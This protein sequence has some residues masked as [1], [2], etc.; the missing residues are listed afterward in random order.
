[1]SCCKA[2][3]VGGFLASL[4]A[5]APAIA[6]TPAEAFARG[7]AQLREGKLDQAIEAF[8]AAAAA[9]HD[10]A[11]YAARAKQLHK[12]AALQERLDKEKDDGPWTRIA[13]ALHLFYRSEHID[14]EA[15]K[16]DQ[17]IHERLKSALSASILADTLLATGRNAEV[18]ELLDGLPDD[19]RDLGTSVVYVV[20]LARAGRKD[21]AIS[22]ANAVKLPEDICPGKAFL[23][24]RMYG[25][26]GRD[27]EAA[28]L[29]TTAFESTSAEKLPNFQKSAKENPDFAT[30]VADEKYASL[31]T[32]KTN[33][34]LEHKDDH[35]K[36]DGRSHC[37]GCPSLDRVQDIATEGG[38][39]SC[40]T[41]G[42]TPKLKLKQTKTPE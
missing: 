23:L 16:I 42:V 9:D 4:L 13:R 2:L 30:L 31:W 34:A 29:L 14:A 26:V 38:E 21:D 18:V 6:E 1:M 15:V 33:P 5:A 39:A 37:M 36:N 25:A 22:A 12:V 24:A 7:Q 11:E 20:A 41:E 8:D 19:Q 3:L 32:L 17:K 10:N 28:K 35:P 40:P 27:E